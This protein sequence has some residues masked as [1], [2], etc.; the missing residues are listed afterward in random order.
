LT[1]ISSSLF[2]RR[3][4]IAL[5]RRLV[6]TTVH[7]EVLECGSPLPLWNEPAPSESGRGLPQ[8]TTLSRSSPRLAV[9]SEGVL[10]TNGTVS[11]EDKR[12]R[13]TRPG[14]T[15]E[16]SVSVDG[17]RQDFVINERPAGEGDLRVELALTGARAEAAAY[18][19]KLILEGS[20]RALA[21]S[22]LRATDA[23]GQELRALLE[24]V[25]AGRLA[26]RVADANATYPL[27]I[28]PTFS[29]ADWVSLNPS[30]L[31]ANGV[32]YAIAVDGSGNVYVGGEFTVIG[33]VVANHIAAWNGNAWSAL[34]SGMSSDRSSSSCVYALAESGTTLYAGA[35]FTTAS[36]LS[37]LV[38]RKNAILSLPRVA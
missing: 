4:N 17:V 29:A 5:D 1:G 21:Y 30:M 19:A 23:I 2:N 9:S 38:S 6:A 25:S 8:A 10:P 22:R 15:E 12:V 3:E 14:L 20:G 13:F 35:Y 26:V 28:D 34:G 16:Y 27:R 18:G 31:G 24:V 7:R 32:V 33:T 11:L 37:A 36:A